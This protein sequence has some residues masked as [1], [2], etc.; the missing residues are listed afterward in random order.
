MNKLPRMRLTFFVLAVVFFI[1]AVTGIC[2]DFHIALF[3]RKLMKNFHI[4][5]GYIMIIFMIV[6]LIDN[7]V[8]IKNIFK[9]KTTS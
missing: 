8:W 5:C 3:D 7:S 2:M 1:I 9:V 4:Y 6:H